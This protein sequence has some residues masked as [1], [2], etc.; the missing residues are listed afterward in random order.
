MSDTNL[1][2]AENAIKTILQVYWWKIWMEISGPAKEQYG[3][4]L[5]M[6]ERYRRGQ[7]QK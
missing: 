4:K 5:Q 7:K 1:S 6:E 2:A 3:Y